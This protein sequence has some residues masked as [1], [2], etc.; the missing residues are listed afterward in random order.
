[1]RIGASAAAPAPARASAACTPAAWLAT[2]VGTLATR[3]SPVA[4]STSTRSVKV[5][6]TSTPTS[7]VSATAPTG[8]ASDGLRHGGAVAGERGAPHVTRLLHRG[9]PGPGHGLAVV[10]QHEVTDAPP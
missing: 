9:R 6:P 3:T 2:V 8:G 10:P 4:S 5:P 7:F 1:G